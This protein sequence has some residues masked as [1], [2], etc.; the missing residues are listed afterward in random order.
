MKNKLILNAIASF[1]W[2]IKR[3]GGK[4]VEEK[5]GEDWRGGKGRRKEETEGEDTGEERRGGQKKG[6]EE[7]GGEERREKEKDSIW[8]VGLGYSVYP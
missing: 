5:R 6:G 7:R 4:G 2:N 1:N 8:G 3:R